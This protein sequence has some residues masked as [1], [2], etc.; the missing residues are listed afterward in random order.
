MYKKIVQ[1]KDTIHF[2][3][4][5][6]ILKSEENFLIIMVGLCN[7]AY[8]FADLELKYLYPVDSYM[9]KI[10]FEY[11]TAKE[12]TDFDYRFDICFHKLVFARCPAWISALINHAC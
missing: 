7:K 6:I 8:Y 3:Y 5:T 12:I 11:D 10:N 2:G 4:E 9:Q 1:R